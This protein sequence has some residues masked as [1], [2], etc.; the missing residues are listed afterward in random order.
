LLIIVF[1]EHG[2]YYDH[3]QP[4]EAV[5]PD[6]IPGRT[7]KPFLLPFDFSRLGLRVPCI[8]VSPWFK[9]DVDSTIYSHST[10][11][12]SMIEAFKLGNFLTERDKAAARL[13]E[14]YLLKRADLEW[15]T[16]T[17]DLEVPVQPSRLDMTQR[18][19]LDGSV[20]MDPHEELRTTLRTRD[21]V[22]SDTAGRFVQT[23]VAKRIEHAAAG[24]LPP[25]P[26]GP[27]AD[28]ISLAHLPATASVSP[29]RIEQLR[30]AR[31]KLST[32]ETPRP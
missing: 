4:P 15:R 32:E 26:P 22:D 21:I 24:N 16:D 17:P 31:C 9:A 28:S 13:T 11:P 27:G 18:E 6:D 30:Q 3:V 20:H 1:D 23:Q 7:D 29:A 10:I 19:I 14:R 25:P 2:G 5:P 8:L 12:G